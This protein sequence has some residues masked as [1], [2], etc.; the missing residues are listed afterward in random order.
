M[1]LNN[2]GFCLNEIMKCIEV[3]GQGGL[4]T[5]VI[6]I[7]DKLFVEKISRDAQFNTTIPFPLLV[8]IWLKPH[9]NISS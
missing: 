8:N 7:F 2:Q 4:N 5:A 3:N 1:R 6:H 9:S